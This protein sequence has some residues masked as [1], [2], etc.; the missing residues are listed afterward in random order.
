MIFRDT[1]TWKQ[2]QKL[3]SHNL[4][5][6]QLAFSPDS[7]Y[8]LSVS[9]DRRWTLFSKTG[10]EFEIVATSD[11]KTG[12]HTRIIWC[13]AWSSDSL[14]FATGSRDGKV[15]IWTKFDKPSETC[16]GQYGAA[17]KYL[18][19]KGECI[20]A[21]DFAPIKFLD[22]YLIV[23]GLE[24]GVIKFYYWNLKEWTL[25][26]T[27]GHNFAHHLTVKRLV[28]RPVGSSAG[29]VRTLQLA[30]CGSDHAVRIYN[31]DLN[32]LTDIYNKTLS[33]IK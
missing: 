21:L 9:R 19:L 25:L 23:V 17:S 30:S 15:V 28:F 8:L 2:N 31:V 1:K 5:V 12:I 27:L 10:E 16:L 26:S 32:K 13:C 33:I 3:C 20:T 29:D 22:G 7:N 6:A 14:Y 18:E 24:T 11:K 4:T